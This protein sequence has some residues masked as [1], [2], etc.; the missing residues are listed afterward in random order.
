MPLWNDVDDCLPEP[1]IDSCFVYHGYE[2]KLAY[3]LDQGWW[4]TDE[5]LTEYHGVEYWMKA[6]DAPN[7]CKKRSK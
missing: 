5:G 1:D 6:P 7:V 3:Y 2:I 4:E